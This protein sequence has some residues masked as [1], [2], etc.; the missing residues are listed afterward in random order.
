VRPGDRLVLFSLETV[1]K[2]AVSVDSRRYFVPLHHS[3]SAFRLLR[4]TSASATCRLRQL[5]S[6]TSEFPL[7]IELNEHGN[8]VNCYEKLLPKQ[9][10]LKADVRHTRDT[11][12]FMHAQMLRCIL[13]GLVY[14]TN[15]N[16]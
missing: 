15:K 5:V 3:S 1:R 11:R 2:L 16:L 4:D 14:R 12:Y 10:A 9:T 6:D 8:Y 13:G 7:T